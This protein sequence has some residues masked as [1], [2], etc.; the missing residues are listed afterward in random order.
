MSQAAFAPHLFSSSREA[1]LLQR[2]Q[3]SA[4]HFAQSERVTKIRDHKLTQ[5]FMNAAQ[6]SGLKT[7]FKL[8]AAGTAGA[9]GANAYGVA[10][11]GGAGVTFAEA[12][13]DYAAWR[14]EQENKSQGLWGMVKNFFSFLGDN[15]AKYTGKLLKNT[16]IGFL[17]AEIGSVFAGRETVTEKLASHI[18]GLSTLGE[19]AAKFGDFITDKIFPAAHAG[20]LSKA[21]M[22]RINESADPLEALLKEKGLMPSKPPACAYDFCTARCRGC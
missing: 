13:R 4:R 22:K 2:L 6:K 11:A 17:G 5:T 18:P 10:L 16:G 21:V 7:A 20:E 8:A 15:K 12:I 19:K 3:S 1:S 9:L 14:K